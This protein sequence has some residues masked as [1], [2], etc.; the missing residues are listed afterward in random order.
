MLK[1]VLTLCLGILLFPVCFGQQTDEKPERV[2]F[3]ANTEFSIQLESAVSTEKSNVG[4]DAN[5]I[6]TED[7]NG[8]GYK[9]EKGSLVY[10]R[11][12]NIEK[13]S[14]KNAT[15]KVCIMFD[16]VKKGEDF[17]TLVATI[18]SVEPNTELIKFVASP[19]FEGGTTLALKGKEIQLEKGGIFRLRLIKDI[20]SK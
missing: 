12:V 5:F 6:F 11:I 17:L 7:V 15:A 10:G 8:E 3:K 16:F 18:I 4:D 2:V 19:T 13:I 20:T 9:I 14:T 1:A